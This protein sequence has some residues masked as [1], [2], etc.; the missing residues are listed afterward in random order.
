MPERQ[1]RSGPVRLSITHPASLMSAYLRRMQRLATPAFVLAAFGAFLGLYGLLNVTHLPFSIPVFQEAA[2][3]K[4]IL[5]VLP[6]YDAATAYEHLAAYSAE[7]VR[8]YYAILAFDVVLM[9]PAYILFLT[10]ALL[11]AGGRV[12]RGR[13]PRGL[14][15]VAWLPAVAGGLNLLEDAI[16]VVL[17]NTF[18]TELPTLA[19]ACGVLT[20]TKS[21][22]L[23]TSLLLVAGGYL[24]IGA[25]R[26]TYALGLRACHV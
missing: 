24:T 9:I 15:A 8:I 12:L 4:T 23:V 2:Q 11:H 17:L 19:A 21:F 16:V 14:H 20:T 10:T 3:G 25:S 26:L 13:L 6:Y 7:A 18:P 1:V 5:N 22:L